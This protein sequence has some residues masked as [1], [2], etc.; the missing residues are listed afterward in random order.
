MSKT[1]RNGE[2]KMKTRIMK[3]ADIQFGKKDEKRR[4]MPSRAG[5]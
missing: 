2:K 5:K 3:D 1:N 4:K